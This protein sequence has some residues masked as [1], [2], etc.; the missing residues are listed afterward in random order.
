MA[1]ASREDQQEYQRGWLA[2]RRAEWLAENGPCASCG[3][4]EGLEVDHIDRADKSA[5]L[6]RSTYRLWSWSEERRLVE[7]AKCQALCRECHRAKTDVENSRSVVHGRPTTYDK[8]GCRCDPCRDAK[9]AY[10]RGG[11]AALR[12]HYEAVTPWLLPAQ[13]GASD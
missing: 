1:Y 2:Q 4:W 13:R 9:L 11:A 5:S 7:L 8:R 3:S 6:R 12:R 10:K